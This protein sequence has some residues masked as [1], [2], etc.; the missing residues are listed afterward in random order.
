MYPPDVFFVYLIV[1][2]SVS[3]IF[4]VIEIAVMFV[5][6]HYGAYKTVRLH[7]KSMVPGTL[8]IGVMTVDDIRVPRNNIMGIDLEE[9][10]SVILKKLSLSQHTQL[11]VYRENID[12]VSGMLHLRK[13]LNFA[14]LGNLN[15]SNLRMCLEDLYF[16]PEGT[17][18]QMQ[19]RN[20]KEE[21]KHIGLIVDEYGDIKGLLTLADI[22]EEI[23]S[24]FTEQAILFHKNI[25]R[26]RDGSY[27]LQ[28]TVSVRTINRKLKIELPTNG[29]K[30]ISGLIVE[31]LETIPESRVCLKLE[32][33]PMEVVEIEEKILKTIRIWPKK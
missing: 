16:I 5:H 8:E 1:L 18:L 17:S 30:T 20:F 31:Y 13:A 29:P 19:L 28:G 6:S 9:E 12:Q 24:E 26:K 10:W 15:R 14:V 25:Q 22:L 3:C 23:A 11:P 27:L 33:Y 21:K 4:S 2:V 7:S 32:G